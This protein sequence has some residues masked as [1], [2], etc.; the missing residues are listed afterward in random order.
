MPC[1]DI[2][3]SSTFTRVR[4][5]T[6]VET[7]TLEK[8]LDADNAGQDDLA[9]KILDAGLL[10]EHMIAEIPLEQNLADN[11]ELKQ[12]A[13]DADRTFG[14][15][16]CFGCNRAFDNNNQTK[17]CPN[18]GAKLSRSDI[19]PPEIKR[20]STTP[21]SAKTSVHDLTKKDHTIQPEK[22]ETPSEKPKLALASNSKK[23]QPRTPRQKQPS[24]GKGKNGKYTAPSVPPAPVLPKDDE[25]EGWAKLTGQDI[26]GRKA[27]KS[28]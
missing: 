13:E 6:D 17:T 24:N 21:T 12:L 22:K 11:S 27:V 5:F 4:L 14:L 20:A 16:V 23:H 25:E 28:R 19:T 9:K 15:T 1:R 3:T 10:V 18:C 26:A 7:I 2:V 8:W